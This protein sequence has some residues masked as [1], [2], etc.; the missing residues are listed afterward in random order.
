MAYYEIRQGFDKGFNSINDATRYAAKLIDAGKLR[1]PVQI[2]RIDRGTFGRK[3]LRLIG[4]VSK[5]GNEGYL[6]FNL[7]SSGNGFVTGVSK[8]NMG[9]KKT[10]K[11]TMRR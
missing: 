4:H 2:F 10:E 1:S 3:K 5:D 7:D 8:V 9:T 11:R 6:Y